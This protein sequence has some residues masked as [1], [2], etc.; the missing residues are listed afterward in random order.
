MSRAKCA[1]DLTKHDNLH[2]QAAAFEA[3]LVAAHVFGRSGGRWQHWHEQSSNSKCRR[4]CDNV[5]DGGVME[6]E[7]DATYLTPEGARSL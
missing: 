2:P 4:E 7:Q 6:D 3:G 1:T 5:C